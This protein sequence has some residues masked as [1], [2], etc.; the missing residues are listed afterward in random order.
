VPTHNPEVGG[1]NPPPATKR[2]SHQEIL[3]V[4]VFL[5]QESRFLT[6]VVVA[7]RPL[8]VTVDEHAAGQRLLGLEEM[9]LDVG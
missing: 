4:T 8:T 6:F 7:A 9:D 3:L 1:S 2:N 5:G